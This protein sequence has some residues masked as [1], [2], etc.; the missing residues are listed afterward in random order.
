MCIDLKHEFLRNIEIYNK[1]TDNVAPMF[2]YNLHIVKD[3]GT[4]KFH[5]FYIA[6][7]E[8][9]EKRTNLCDY[10]DDYLY[11]HP[12]KKIFLMIF[13]SDE[14]INKDNFCN[15]I[16]NQEKV[17]E[18]MDPKSKVKIELFKSFVTKED[19]FNDTIISYVSELKNRL[20]QMKINAVAIEMYE[21]AVL[22]R[23]TWILAKKRDH[24][25][26]N[27]GLKEDSLLYSLLIK[28]E[29]DLHKFV[30]NQIK[31]FT[32]EQKNTGDAKKNPPIPIMDDI[33]VA[34]EKL[35]TLLIFHNVLSTLFVESSVEIK[36]KKYKIKTISKVNEMENMPVACKMSASVQHHGLFTE[37]ISQ[38]TM[39]VF[40]KSERWAKLSYIKTNKLNTNNGMLKFIHQIL[41]NK[42]KTEE[43]LAT[44][45]PRME[46]ELPIVVPKLCL[47]L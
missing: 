44:I 32:F 13:S 39:E 29:D 5:D 21:Q 10:V 25:K 41:V 4:S 36:Q 46:G 28:I 8:N 23:L 47:N 22:S 14:A 18:F 20:A 9:P 17:N 33:K 34:T 12:Y 11:I 2:M 31:K 45:D 6:L 3:L 26:E 27:E 16:Y 38:Q 42:V 7:D 35:L 24:L 37:S 15:K 19:T 40:M 30:K 1:N 43:A